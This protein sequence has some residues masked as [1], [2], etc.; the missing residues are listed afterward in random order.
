MTAFRLISF[1]AH[2]ALELVIG[3]ALIVAPFA[4]AFGPGATVAGVSIGALIVGLAFGAATLEL[5]RGSIGGHH[6]YDWGAV[7][8]IAVAAA[9][10]AAV[11]ESA[12]AITFAIAAVAMTALALT[13]R[14]SLP[15]RNTRLRSSIT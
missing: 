4:L 6:A 3:L 12:A 10:L 14:Y 1:G 9:G 7:A 11:G 15:R 2:G 13:T 5:D 8:G